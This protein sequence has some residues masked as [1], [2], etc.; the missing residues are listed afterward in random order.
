ML[1]KII[2]LLVLCL[3]LPAQ[4]S[5]HAPLKVAVSFSIIADMVKQVGG[6]DV[7]VYSLVAPGVDSH[8]FRPTPK[9]VVSVKKSDVLIMNGLGFETWM[10][11]IISASGFKGETLVLGREVKPIEVSEEEAHHHHHGDEHEESHYE[12]QQSAH[13]HHDHHEHAHKDHDEHNVFYDPHAWQDVSYAMQY[14]DAIARTLIKH[15]PEHA[16]SLQARAEAYKASLANIESAFK[17]KIK[18]V[19]KALKKV[20]TD[21]NAFAYFSKAY[22]I[23]FYAVRGLS[24]ESGASAKD[25]AR[26]I[27]EMKNNKVKL[28][29]LEAMTNTKLS[30]QIAKESNAIVGGELYTGVLPKTGPD[31]TYL[32]MMQHNFDAIAK[33]LE[34]LQK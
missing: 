17:E 7:E 20:V 27:R 14:V 1:K 28:I 25:V 30:Q 9:T 21:H 24:T 5:D 19:P 8:T 16:N 13:L 15:R 2:A 34:Q 33:G 10:P 22:G 18:N 11:R 29:Y 26:V 4:S 3:T 32:G 6:D 23:K 31:S 12:H